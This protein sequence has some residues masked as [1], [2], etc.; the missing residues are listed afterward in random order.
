MTAK[1]TIK[2]SAFSFQTGFFLISSIVWTFL[3]A[4]MGFF[5]NL[6]IAAWQFP[7]GVLISLI[8]NYLV[9]I[10]NNEELPGMNKYL[11]LGVPLLLLGGFIILSACFYD[12][13]FDG[14]AY[15]MEAIIQLGAG[16]NPFH[17]LLPDSVNQAIWVNHYGKGMETVQAAIF[18]SFHNIEAGKATNIMLW[19]G[20][21][22]VTLSLICKLEHLS[23]RKALLISTL[24]ACNPIVFNQLISYYVDGALAS[25]LL[26]LLVTGILIIKKPEPRYFLLLAAVVIL[27]INIKFTAF[28]YLGLYIGGMLVYLVFYKRKSAYTRL[29]YTVLIAGLIAVLAGFNPYIT[30]TMRFGHPFYPLMGE[31]KVDIIHAINLPVGFED[32][33]GTERFFITAFGRTD[34]IYPQS[35]FEPEFKIPFTFNKIDISNAGVVDTRIGGFGPWY[36]GILILSLVLLFILYFRAGSTLFFK[37]IVLLSLLIILSI[38]LMPESWWARYIP[39]FWFLPVC[40]LLAAE[41]L[42]ADRYRRL[43]QLIYIAMIGNLVFCS[44]GLLFNMIVTSKINYQLAQL[45]SSSQIILVDWGASASNRTRFS[46]NH[47]PF[48]VTNLKGAIAGKNYMAGSQTW[49]IMPKDIDPKIKKPFILRIMET[50]LPYMWQYYGR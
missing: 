45:K 13:S 6:T 26:Y 4:A 28:L 25:V 12:R 43:K 47:I 8:V 22:F 23:L 49:F 9:N 2:F 35:K 31:H 19:A 7:V 41:V 21:L 29:F 32:K 18:C 48:K 40:W 33:G 36:S 37:R 14:Q 27:L 20:S 39:Q 17:E 3:L 50:Y 16:W 42:L 15:H 34:N 30:N 24:L 38:I 5:L 44:G 46:T 1:T 10:R 11:L